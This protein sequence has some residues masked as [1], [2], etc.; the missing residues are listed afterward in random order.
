[1]EHTSAFTPSVLEQWRRR[2]NLLPG[3]ALL[4]L[5]VV[6]WVYIAYQA[7]TMDSM[8]SMSGA[9][10]STMGGFVPFV[11]GWTAMMVAMMIPA[12]LPLILL[13]RVVA[14]RRLRPGRARGGI[15]ALLLG[16]IAVWAIAGLPVYV[17]ALTAEAAG[18]Y[19]IVLPAVLLVIGG[20]YQFTSLKRSCHARCSS[21]L[22]FLMQK[23]KPG[24]AGA[25]RLGVLHGVDCLGC[26][27]GLMI[28][29]VALGMM[30]LALVF[31]AALIIFA[32]KTLPESHRIAR[33]L[34]VLM[35]TGAVVLLG[36][37]LLGGMEAGTEMDPEMEMSPGMP[38]MEDSTQ[39]MEEPGMESM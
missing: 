3:L 29:L 25:L 20:I 5:T 13:Y 8:E 17:Y 16:Y 1:L 23:W 37:S 32:E 6:G 22:F 26:C 7:G 24:T 39:N 21:P 31:T 4:V 14:R 9:R 2:E 12:T 33:P 27:V 35:M 38:S 15:A 10:I 36:F 30:N 34:G 11:L 19:A 28:G 18:S